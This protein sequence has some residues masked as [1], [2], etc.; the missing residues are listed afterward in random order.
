MRPAH[1]LALPPSFTA[2]LETFDVVDKICTFLGKRCVQLTVANLSSMVPALGGVSLEQRLLQIT[3]LTPEVAGLQWVPQRTA[4]EGP[5]VLE[6]VYLQRSTAKR[7]RAGLRKAMIARL[8]VEHAKVLAAT[9]SHPKKKRKR[10]VTA[11][12][13]KPSAPKTPKA[14]CA[15]FNLTSDSLSVAALL[16]DSLRPPPRPTVAAAAARSGADDATKLCFVGSADGTAAKPGPAQIVAALRNA[17]FYDAQIV[18]VH[19]VAARRAR[20][21]TLDVALGPSTA[22]CVALLTAGQPLWAHQANA[23]NAARAGRDVAVCTATA[24]GKSL[25][26]LVPILHAIERGSRDGAPAQNGAGAG[27]ATALVLFPT[28]AL[29]QD[30]LRAV[31]ELVRGVPPA[32]AAIGAP[33]S[34]PASA[35]A[36]AGATVCLRRSFMYRYISR[37][38][39]SQFDSLPLTSLR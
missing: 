34:A 20:T 8:N 13:S 22:R 21:A 29:A 5:L 15:T 38:S 1:P 3:T 27:T 33:G 2:L 35:A 11:V 7:R 24:S 31:N 19:E 26:Y 4:V 9:L 28:K 16:G 6:F 32:G 39:C 23:I 10:C 18:H 30:Q 17:P 37:V 25:C 14:W 36:A 12:K